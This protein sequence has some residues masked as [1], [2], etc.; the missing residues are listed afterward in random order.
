VLPPVRDFCRAVPL[1]DYLAW[2]TL[3]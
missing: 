1:I 2:G 3:K